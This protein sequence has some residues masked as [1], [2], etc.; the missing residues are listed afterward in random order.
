M[1]DRR[2]LARQLFKSVKAEKIRMMLPQ[3]LKKMDFGQLEKWCANELSGMSKSRILCILNGKPM[4][5]SSDTSETD[6]SGPS[7]EI[8]SD[9]EEWFTD[10]DISKKDEG[11]K[12]LKGKIKKERIK[13]KG[14]SQIIKKNDSKKVPDN[15]Y[16]NVQVKKEDDTD[17]N[18]EKEA[19]SLL[20][21][22]ELEMRARAI[23]ALIRKEED[24]IPN[25][26]KSVTDND[27]S[28]KT[29]AT[30]AEQDEIKE[31]E[32]CRRQLERIISAQQNSAEDEDVVLVVQPTPTIELLSSDS[33]GEPH[34]GVRVNKKLQ[35][36]RVIENEDNINHIE[37]RDL[38]NVHNIN[39]IENSKEDNIIKSS[40]EIHQE[41][42]S[43]QKNDVL[44]R[45]HSNNALHKDNQSKSSSKRRKT[46]K[47]S[48]IKEQSKD[49][50]FEVNAQSN[51]SQNVIDIKNNDCSNVKLNEKI[52]EKEE[53]NV[54]H[55]NSSSPNKQNSIETLEISSKVVLD[56]EKSIDLDEIIDL[57]NYCDDMDDIE[58]NENDKNNQIVENKQSNPQV[59]ENSSQK[60]NATETWA[61][62]YYQTDDVQ[63][64]IKESKIQSEIRKRLR[65]RQ[66]LS[67][68]NTSP[69]N[70]PSSPPTID[71]TN[72]KVT[73]KHPMGSVDEYLALKHTAATS[74][75]DSNC[76]SNTMKD[77][78]DINRSIE[79]DLVYSKNQ[80]IDKE[81]NLS[82]NINIDDT[83][84]T[85]HEKIVNTIN[86]NPG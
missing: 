60:S 42:S 84:I 14:K 7:L 20:D 28:N 81:S 47:K 44:K 30:A 38:N 21:L 34:S 2:E 25:T 62:R 36:E 76:G 31:K 57:D 68:L 83:V 10:E 72:N 71:T 54:K 19:D 63:S 59:A 55:D 52:N 3:T 26:S 67:K 22:L 4:L 82:D 12:T 5:E 58:S 51:V 80:K 69:K 9:T 32:N 70:P 66:R 37:N 11:S 65:E 29:A 39:S 43:T 49:I 24:I 75:T 6:D 15:T 74:L 27:I 48:H 23:R 61:S 77:K 16:K 50:T 79:N 33:E 18:K 46:K 41:I 35:N 86:V 40:I 64:V 8:I 85:K 78:A 56:E 73:E 53:N 13:Q 17:K 1:S 45:I